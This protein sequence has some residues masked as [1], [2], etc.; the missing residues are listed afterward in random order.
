MPLR[1]KRLT[2]DRET[3]AGLVTVLTPIARRLATD[4]ELRNELRSA[5]DSLAGV[6]RKT[7]SG[8]ERRRTTPDGT[9]LA[10]EESLDGSGT[11]ASRVA[12]EIVGDEG[13][14]RHDHARSKRRAARRAGAH[15]A[16]RVGA[17][18]AAAA[19]AAALLA[20]RRLRSHGDA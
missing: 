2:A 10:F 18:A 16:L 14:S 19:G 1:R 11:E 15:R 8:Q 6:Y 5:A 12:A 20:G 17:A 7:R 3:I 4:K 9:V 13:S